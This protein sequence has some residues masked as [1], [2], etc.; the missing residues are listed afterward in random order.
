MVTFPREAGEDGTVDMAIFSNFRVR[1]LFKP[2][3][4]TTGSAVSVRQRIQAALSFYA[5]N[6]RLKSLKLAKEWDVPDFHVI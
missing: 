4:R 1:C 6:A 3:L 2:N 5:S